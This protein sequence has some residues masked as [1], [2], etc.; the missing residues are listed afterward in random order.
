VSFQVA[1]EVLLFE[2]WSL[3]LIDEGLGT[4]EVLELRQ[5]TSFAS[6][7]KSELAKRL[8]G[9]WDTTHPETPVGLYWAELY[10]LRIQIVHRGYLP[11]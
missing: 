6:L 9:S 11:K 8:G 5:D 4:S 10:Q 2:V 3:V 1:A 7:V